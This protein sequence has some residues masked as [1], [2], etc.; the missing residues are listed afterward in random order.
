MSTVQVENTVVVANMIELA[1]EVLTKIDP[2]VIEVG[3]DFQAK[4][5]LAEAVGAAILTNIIKKAGV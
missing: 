4:E 2:D 1:T 5:E 3:N